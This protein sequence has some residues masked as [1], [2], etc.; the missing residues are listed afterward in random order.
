M[1]AQADELTGSSS[2]AI[3]GYL[4]RE[5]RYLRKRERLT[6]ALWT[7]RGGGMQALLPG[8][9][10]TLALDSDTV[11]PPQTGNVCGTQQLRRE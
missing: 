3:M 1:E 5:V 11:L 10:R 9:S 6:G 7:S 8:S 2:I 4:T